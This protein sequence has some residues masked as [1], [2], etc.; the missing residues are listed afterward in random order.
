MVHVPF[1]SNPN[2][3]THKPATGYVGM[4][5]SERHRHKCRFTSPSMWTRNIRSHRRSKWLSRSLSARDS[6]LFDEIEF[7]APTAPATYSAAANF[8]FTPI[9]ASDG[10]AWLTDDGATVVIS[11]AQPERGFVAVSKSATRAPSKAASRERKWGGG[12][13]CFAVKQIPRSILSPVPSFWNRFRIFRF[14][15]GICFLFLFFGIRTS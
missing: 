4:L 1:P 2:T 3:R 13:S 11:L 14:M 15:W 7:Q 9:W 6:Q 8:V 5:K 12:S 10:F